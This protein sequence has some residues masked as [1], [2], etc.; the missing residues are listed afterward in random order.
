ME[1]Q[2]VGQIF[3][4]SGNNS[5]KLA[6]SGLETDSA[7]SSSSSSVESQIEK[8]IDMHNISPN[9][10]NMLVRAGVADLPIPMVLPNGRL[11]LDGQ[12]GKMGDVRTDYIGQ[13]EQ[14]IKYS[15]SI[16]DVNQANFLENRLAIVKELHGKDYLQTEHA[17]GLDV[18]A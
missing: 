2:G 6:Q 3:A 15:K 8:R 1:I 17:L 13:I 9:E 14:S 5:N 7:F 18:M 16:G 12:Q 11:Y 10:Y 4:T